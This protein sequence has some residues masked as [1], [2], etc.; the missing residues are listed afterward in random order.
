MLPGP[1]PSRLCRT[2]D[3]DACAAAGRRDARLSEPHKRPPLPSRSENAQRS[4][5]LHCSAL[6]PRSAGKLPGVVHLGYARD[7]RS[8][9]RC[10]ARGRGRCAAACAPSS[11][12]IRA[13]RMRRSRVSRAH[14]G[15]SVTFARVAGAFPT[16][17]AE[18]LWLLD[19][20][21]TG[22]SED[23]RWTARCFLRAQAPASEL[24][25]G[26]PQCAVAWD[27]H[28]RTTSVRAPARFHAFAPP[29][30]SL[31]IDHPLTFSEPDPMLLDH[32][33]V[34]IWQDQ[35]PAQRHSRVPSAGG[36]K[37][38]RGLATTGGHRVQ[39]SS[40]S[41][42]KSDLATRRRALEAR[43]ARRAVAEL[44]HGRSRRFA[45]RTGSPSDVGASARIC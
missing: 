6:R 15:A 11:S 19:P 37:E 26:D 33:P 43:R 5:G 38:Q 9:A 12:S 8:E 4:E 39:Q 45:V 35:P 25:H 16:T 34:R 7:K 2:S 17:N 42:A 32:P 1:A 14:A 20:D 23:V 21:D 29:R 13:L 28:R 41:A 27:Q 44:R 10:E 3:A 18:P 30:A 36:D 22:T 24:C 40:R 31:A